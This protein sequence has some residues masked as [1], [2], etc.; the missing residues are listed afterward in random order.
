MHHFLDDFQV[1]D[2]SV[3]R[4]LYDRLLYITCSQNWE[5][6]GSHFW[7]KQCMELV[8]AVA[9]NGTSIQ[10]SSQTNLLPAATSVV[11]LADSHDR[12]AFAMVTKMKE[13]PMDVESLD[14]NKEE[15]GIQDGVFASHLLF[16]VRCKAVF[17][18]CQKVDCKLL[19]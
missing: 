5:A 3:K 18:D 2:N 16:T 6:M 10:S 13:E 1:F 14:G 12:A 15:V 17:M 9:V 11:S 8:S 19:L 7:I 4:R